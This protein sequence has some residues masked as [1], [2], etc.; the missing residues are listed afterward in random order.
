MIRPSSLSTFDT[1]TWNYLKVCVSLRIDPLLNPIQHN[2][3]LCFVCILAFLTVIVN[4]IEY[5]PALG[6][7][8]GWGVETTSMD[9]NEVKVNEG[10]YHVIRNMSNLPTPQCLEKLVSGRM[11]FH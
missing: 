11:L 3:G 5:S 1:A 6:S 2:D 7:N 9:H 10:Q 8:P 4:D